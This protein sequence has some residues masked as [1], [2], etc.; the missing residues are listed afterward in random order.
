MFSQISSVHRAFEEQARLS[1]DSPA[2]LFE[3]QV[4]SY[5]TLNRRANQIARF[6]V[7]SGIGAGSRVALSLDRSPELIAVLIA[8]LKT[9]G[10]FVPIDSSFPADRQAF[11]LEDS[12]ASLLIT[13]ETLKFERQSGDD[14]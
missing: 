13:R 12:G 8:I 11:M 9:G 2:L 4:W 7:S 6:L 3:D 10:V 1:P 14:L 5:Q